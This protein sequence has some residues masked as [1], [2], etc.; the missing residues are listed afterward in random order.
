M[1]SPRQGRRKLVNLVGPTTTRCCLSWEPGPPHNGVEGLP[2]GCGGP[3]SCVIR[4]FS[5]VGQPL[6]SDS[7]CRW[8]DKPWTEHYHAQDQKLQALYC[9]ET[10]GESRVVTTKGSDFPEQTGPTEL[11]LH[12]SFWVPKWKLRLGAPF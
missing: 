11:L 12:S 2:V 9:P 7:P 6:A 10:P 1:T 4:T 8:S 3:G 5:W